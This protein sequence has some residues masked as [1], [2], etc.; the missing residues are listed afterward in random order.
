MLKIQSIELIN[1]GVHSNLRIELSNDTTLISGNN[2]TGKS[3]II[4][5]I[6]IALFD[7]KTT[8]IKDLITRGS[9]FAEI[10]IEFEYSNHTCSIYRRI[11]T[12]QKTA[13]MVDGIL[14]E[15][16][17]DS[18]AKISNL[19]G[20]KDL[21]K[22]FNELLYI[23][24]SYL[25]YLFLLEK[26]KRKLILENILDIE[27]YNISFKIR[28]LSKEIEAEL[29]KKKEFA[30]PEKI[31]ELGTSIFNLE[32]EIEN[33]KKVALKLKENRDK[34]YNALNTLTPVLDKMKQEINSLISEI[35]KLY[36]KKKSLSIGICP[37]CSQPIEVDQNEIVSLTDK[38]KERE[39]LLNA[40]IDQ[41][42]TLSDKYS[43]SNYEQELNN[44]NNNIE[45]VSRQ[46][47][48]R[49]GRVEQLKLELHRLESVGI[50]SKRINRLEE[51][52][53]I[54]SK[55]KDKSKDLPAKVSNNFIGSITSMAN[56][57]LTY[58]PNKN[59]SIEIIDYDLLVE[60]NGKKLSYELLSDG[61]KVIVALL[62]RIAMINRLSDL[63]FYILDE[64]TINLDTQT[65]DE[66]L[67]I[68][69]N[70]KGQT[71][72]IS[73]DHTFSNVYNKEVSL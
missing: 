20:I 9:E 73:H 40:K 46:I 71:I 57:L 4:R 22:F 34:V 36:S 62:I 2:G 30:S 53:E 19:F 37:T 14:T 47:Y 11:G 59:I 38:I 58:V 25:T 15:M 26:S 3:T 41:Q 67:T 51:L 61:E 42:K 21:P 17:R 16:Y 52:K 48:L 27:K 69:S 56:Q 49:Q 6:G 24:S 60:I 43:E 8:T 23:R 55:L 5:A 7:Y 65:K 31:E 66:L 33:Y 44:I 39:E 10:T 29:L 68:F 70:I 32:N 13:L 28:E 72:V 18:Y 45:A 64:P 63:K 54:L 50:D 1:F 35:G 12:E